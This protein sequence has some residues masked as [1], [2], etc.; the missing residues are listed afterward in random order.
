VT[1][2][3]KLR[4]EPQKKK[5]GKVTGGKKRGKEGKIQVEGA[6]LSKLV[7]KLEKWIS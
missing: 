3:L 4:R 7:T 1:T 6:E 5:G 2:P